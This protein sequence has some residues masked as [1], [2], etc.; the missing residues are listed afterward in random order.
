LGLA[1]GVAT[2]AILA[3][4]VVAVVSVT[5]NAEVPEP[6]LVLAVDWPVLALGVLAYAVLVVALTG[7]VIR[8]AFRRDVPGRALGVET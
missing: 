3:R 8:T 2:G 5:A 1:G 4:L 7:A 6:P